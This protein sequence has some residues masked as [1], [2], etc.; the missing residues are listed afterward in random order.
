MR[1]QK[2]AIYIPVASQPSTG[3]VSGDVYKIGSMVGVAGF[4]TQTTLNSIT[5]TVIGVLWVT[6]VYTLPKKTGAVWTIGELLYWDNQL[7]VC[8]TVDDSTDVVIGVAVS[9][10]ASGDVTGA[11]R[12]NGSFRAAA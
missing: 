12:L 10:Q 2:L 3:M 9:A 8:S 5:T 11:V 7:G 4:T 6:G 1:Q